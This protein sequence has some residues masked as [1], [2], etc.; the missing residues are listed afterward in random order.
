MLQGD[1]FPRE[2]PA[3]IAAHIA[4][5]LAA[6]TAQR[7]SVDVIV[8]NIDVSILLPL[9]LDKVFD[10]R[11]GLRVVFFQTYHGEPISYSSEHGYGFLAR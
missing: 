6:E 11:D 10:K 3:T 2:V 1:V 4:L 9:P 5:L 7:I 8:P